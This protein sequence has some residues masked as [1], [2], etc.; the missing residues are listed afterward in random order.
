MRKDTTEL[1]Y[2]LGKDVTI[3]SH[4]LAEIFDEGF[5]GY[6]TR[7]RPTGIFKEN[8]QNL[9]NKKSTKKTVERKAR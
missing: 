3:K 1:D 7:R 4:Y 6:S 5:G 2:L 9:A 8:T